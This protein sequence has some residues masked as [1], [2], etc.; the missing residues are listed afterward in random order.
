MEIT[1]YFNGLSLTIT[2]TASE[3]RDAFEYQQMLYDE[4]DIRE[5]LSD[6]LDIGSEYPDAFL[7]DMQDRTDF[8]D[9]AVSYYRDHYS[10]DQPEY[11]Q[12]DEAVTVTLPKYYADWE[13][14]QEGEA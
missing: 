14:R 2:L 5:I 9:N 10:S 13:A 7:T 6:M 4:A 8:I 3:L 1:R 12:R 11:D